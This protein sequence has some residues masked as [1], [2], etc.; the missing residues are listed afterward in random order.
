MKKKLGYI[1][2]GKMGVNMV[3]RL[4]EKK[5]EV[6]VSTHD[7]SAVDAI[8]LKGAIGASD[9]KDV[10]RRLEGPRL[11]W[12][13]VPWEKVD[14]VLEE[15]VPELGEGDVVID[16][17]NSPYKKSI[18]R[19]EILAKK[20]IE[21]V[22]A[23]VSGGPDGAL[24]GACVMVGGNKEVFTR[25]EELFRDLSV[26]NGFGYMG[27]Q[28]SGHFVKMV[29]N[30]IEYGMMQSIAE[31]FAIMRESGFG[32]DLKEVAR[33]YE[34]KSVIESRLVSWLKESYEEN[35]TE[36]EGV[37]GEVSHSGEG[38]WTVEEAEALGVSADVIKSSLEFRDR[39]KGNPSY[40]GKVVS[41][42]RERFGGHDV[43]SDK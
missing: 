8:V 6:V 31:G 20:G 27:K 10:I 25:Y 16:G 36:L 4:L 2:L 41:A 11:I 12:L 17:G 5:Y 23:G 22:D 35:G 37:S 26:E 21:F 29:H 19:G 7:R 18:E 34:H 40:A 43:R 15:I 32:L 13:M 1:G 24:N 38:L 42:L 14:E 33:V 30:G 9:N 3:E 28:G 39:S